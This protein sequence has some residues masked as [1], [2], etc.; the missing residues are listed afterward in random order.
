LN[1]VDATHRQSSSGPGCTATSSNLTGK[2][3]APCAA[4]LCQA[5]R[6]NQKTKQQRAR[7]TNTPHPP[8]TWRVVGT[9]QPR[10]DTGKQA[11][12]TSM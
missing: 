9:Q 12:D 7:I 10:H 3:V 2:R 1:E 11:A 6:K 8:V 4:M 5:S